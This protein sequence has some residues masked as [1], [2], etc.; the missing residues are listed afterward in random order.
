MLYISDICMI[1]SHTP[2]VMIFYISVEFV[3]VSDLLDYINPNH[4]TKG[5]DAA[6]KRRNQVTTRPRFTG[7]N[8]CH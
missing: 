6:A 1:H 8:N 2:F 5:R 3:S 4:D 7:L